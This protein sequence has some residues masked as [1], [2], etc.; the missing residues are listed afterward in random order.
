MEE[1][2]DVSVNFLGVRVWKAGSRF[3]TGPEFKPTSSWQPLRADSAHAPHC[4]TLWPAARLTTPCALSRDPSIFKKAKQELINRFLSHFA[5]ESVT[6]HLK[7]TD[8]LAAIGRKTERDGMWACCRFPPCDLQNPA[9]SVCH[10][11][12]LKGNAGML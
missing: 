1:I 10:F 5:S 11:P 3:V 12:G 2:S 9:S 6:A 4:H 8:R 7:R